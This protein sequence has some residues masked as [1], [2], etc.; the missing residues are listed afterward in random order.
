M[1]RSTTTDRE[2]Q[3]PKPIITRR[4]APTTGFTDHATPSPPAQGIRFANM[5]L[6]SGQARLDPDTRE[7]VDGDI[8][9]VAML[10]E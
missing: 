7:A 2:A 6:V 10:D 4:S 9:R 8:D 5:P 3:V 1:P